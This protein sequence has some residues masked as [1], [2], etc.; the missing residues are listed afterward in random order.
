MNLEELKR[1]E[2]MKKYGNYEKRHS[3]NGD[4]THNNLVCPRCY[5]IMGLISESKQSFG[6]GRAL[7]GGLLLG[8]I[9]LAIGLTKKKNKTIA[10]CPRCGMEKKIR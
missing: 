2:K 3:E 4:P 7:A 9:G 1:V 8:P 6:A 10:H 5:E